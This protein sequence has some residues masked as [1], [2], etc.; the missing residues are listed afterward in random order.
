MKDQELYEKEKANS[1]KLNID[2]LPLLAKLYHKKLLVC[3]ISIA[4]GILGIIVAL[5]SDRKYT[6]SEVVVP[7]QEQDMKSSLMN[8]LSSFMD[9]STAVDIDAPMDL[10]LVRSMMQYKREKSAFRG[11]DS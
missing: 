2:L 3:T 7:E 10:Y 5:T 9:I 6:A 8:S 4:F 1:Q 11:K